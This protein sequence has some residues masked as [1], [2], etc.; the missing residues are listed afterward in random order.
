MKYVLKLA[1]AVTVI[2]SLISQGAVG[3]ALGLQGLDIDNLPELEVINSPRGGTLLLSDSPEMVA[4]D[5][6]LYQDKVEGN[7]RL[8]F[9]HVN[10]SNDVKKMDVIVENT[11]RNTAHVT[12]SRHSLSGP[13]YAWMSVGKEAITSYLAGSEA[14]QINIPAGGAMPLSASMSDNVLMPNM[15][16]NGIFD[17]VTDQPV[18]VKVIMLPVLEESK[19]FSKTAKILPPDQV[20]LRGTFAGA[21]RQIVPAQPY[22]PVLDGLVALT[23]ADNKIDPYLEGIDATDGSKVVDYGN[24]G[25][26]YQILFPSRSI[27]KIAYY[28]VPMGGEYAGAIGIKHPDVKWS[29]LAVPPNMV[30]F[31]KNKSGDSAFLGTYDCGDTLSF[32]FSPPGASN[33][34]VR[35]VVVPQ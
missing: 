13:D 4:A 34:P 3:A 10:A 30:Y 21:N 27:G 12:V 16:I 5:G 24:Y 6:I 26:V 23:L 22:D 20:H 31:G 2:F 33:L 7:V 9:Y 11:S 35:I 14:Y 8:F 25:V 19:K 15:L 29:P 17:F 32:T 28:L 1:L 18:T